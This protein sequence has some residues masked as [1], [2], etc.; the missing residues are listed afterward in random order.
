MQN[1]INALQT[2]LDKLG[3]L[4]EKREDIYND[5]STKWQDSDKGYDYYEITQTLETAKHEL[6]QSIETLND[7]I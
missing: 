6:E 1:I 5:R 3:L 2:Q 4:I 7:L